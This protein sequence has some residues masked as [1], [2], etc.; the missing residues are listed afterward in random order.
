V[1]IDIRPRHRRNARPPE[2]NCRAYLQWLRGRECF[3]ADRGG[4]RGKIE[5][6]HV[7]CA[8]GKGIATKVADKWAIPLCS[9]HHAEQSGVTGSFRTRGSWATFQLRYGFNAIDVA[10]D[11]WHL[12]PGRIAWERKLEARNG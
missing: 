5:A 2:K 3:L 1:K 4:C 7:D 12:W 9:G 11:Y 10:G 6:A 8:G